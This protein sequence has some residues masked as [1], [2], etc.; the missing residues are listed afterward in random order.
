MALVMTEKLKRA[1]GLM[2][3]VEHLFGKK[4]GD[5]LFENKKKILESGLHEKN[6]N[7]KGQKLKIDETDHISAQRI[8]SRQQ[9]SKENI[10]T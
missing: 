8:P 10:P 3:A 6:L 2:F 9:N 5:Y 4:V 1:Y 7:A